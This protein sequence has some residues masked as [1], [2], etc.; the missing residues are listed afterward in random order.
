MGY[1]ES[2][3]LWTETP[4]RTLGNSGTVI[5]ATATVSSNTPA[6]IPYAFIIYED[7]SLWHYRSEAG[8]VYVTSMT[9]EAPTESAATT[10]GKV[11]ADYR[12]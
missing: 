5:A 8:W 1:A 9:G 12:K 4:V 2:G 11:K 6:A 7:G 10:W 3:E